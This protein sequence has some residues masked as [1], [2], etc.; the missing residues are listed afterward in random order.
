MLDTNIS[1]NSILISMESTLKIEADPDL[2]VSEVLDASIKRLENMYACTFDRDIYTLQGENQL[3]ADNLS[4]L[5]KDVQQCLA[6]LSLFISLKLFHKNLGLSLADINYIGYSREQLL[7]ALR[8][9]QDETQYKKYGAEIVSPLHN[10]LN[11]VSMC[12]IKRLFI[13]LL[14]FDRLGLTEGVAIVAQLLYL[15]GLIV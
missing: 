4:L 5:L 3:I 6:Q 10:S 12:A 14:M 8:Y 15:G 7:T 13:V 2:K 1:I 11:N 9:L